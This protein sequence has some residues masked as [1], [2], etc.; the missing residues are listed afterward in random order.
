MEETARQL[1]RTA[2]R[3]A[4][5]SARE[6]QGI[7]VPLPIYLAFQ[8]M[9]R[10]K[11]RFLMVGLVIALITTL[12][13]FIAGLA[14]GLGSGN[15]EYLDKL[16]A[17]LVVFQENTDLSTSASRIGW[18]KR[19]DLRRIDGV[20]DVGLVG[21]SRVSIILGDDKEPL[22][23]SF[24]GVEPGKPGEPPALEGRGLRNKR[25]KEAVIDRNVALRTGLQVGDKFTIKS[26]QGTDEEFYDLTVAGISD[27]RQNF[28]QPSIFVPYVVWDDMKPQAVIAEDPD[29]PQGEVIFNIAA[30]QLDEPLSWQVMAQRLQNDVQKI[31]A[32]DR[33]TAYEA[34]PGYAEQQST[35]NTIRI[36]T[37]LIGVLVLGG[38]FQ[39]QTLQ[40]VAQIGM[41]KA[42]G[43]STLT[44][45]VA[46]I[47]QIIF[48]TIL[49]VLIGTAGTFGLSL[50]LPP[51]VP[52]TFTPETA[53]V[54]I[55]SLLVIGP[56]A[57]L[58]SL[59]VLLRV[60]PLTALGLAS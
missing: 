24:I 26:I 5:D 12:V 22:G 6:R 35:L 34:T 15:I 41:L 28:L 51:T 40:K 18:S 1:E 42:I 36:F 49:G 45:A 57:G 23:I 43:A 55:V 19:N 44:I 59:V 14:E 13:L 7:I 25:S 10:N 4:R 31:E 60:E 29:M 52:I 32:V 16:N 17:D 48:T 27:S 38:F 56:M 58:I 11:V 46:F 33:T 30:V 47:L 37:M 50:G 53:V 21:F 9:W 2:V 39:I 54:A 20:K 3:T 8:E